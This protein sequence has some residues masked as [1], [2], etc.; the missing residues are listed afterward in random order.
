MFKNRLASLF[1]AALLPVS[2]HA[3]DCPSAD[4]A[5]KGFVLENTGARSEFHKAEGQIVKT[6]NHFGGSQQQTVFSF[7][8]LFD[9]ARF[10]KNE[11]YAMHPLSD[12]S[13]ISSAEERR[14]NQ[15]HFL[16]AWPGRAGG[17]ALE[18]GID[19]RRTGELQSRRMQIQ[20]VQDQASDQERRRAGRHLERALFA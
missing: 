7:A 16:T 6:V 14:S 2:V 4:T 11:Q 12:L 10:S 13:R 5:T 19:R 15:R 20:G 18:P 8:G 3:A 1:I 17:Y 9:L